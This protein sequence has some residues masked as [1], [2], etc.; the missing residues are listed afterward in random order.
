MSVYNGFSLEA[1]IIGVQTSSVS[2]VGSAEGR[3]S[4]MIPRIMFIYL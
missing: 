1:W 3:D 2:Y 4:R